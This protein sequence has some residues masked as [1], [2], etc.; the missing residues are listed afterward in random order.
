MNDLKDEWAF[1]A[2]MIEVLA[3]H[4]G[5][6]CEVVL[7]D[8]AKPVDRTIVAIENGHITK[9]TVGGHG[10]NIGLAVLRGVTNE[11]Y[12]SNYLTQT[13]DGKLLRSS[14]VYIR[15]LDGKA[16]GSVCIN[17]DITDLIIA[18]KAIQEVTN[19][20]NR[21][22][23]QVYTNNVNELLDVLI[24]ES[25]EHVGVPVAKM[26]KD[27]KVKGIKYLDKKGAFLIKKAGD[28]IAKFY[29]VSKYTIYNYLELPDEEPH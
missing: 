10:T 7:H 18:E 4:F 6:N 19:H 16:I 21:G 20:P 29:D 15:N 26:D 17:T 9:R 5:R 11:A 27:Q 25:I 2:T 22:V 23:E 24:K 14:T 1:L 28:K 13:V 3:K 12:K 8:Y